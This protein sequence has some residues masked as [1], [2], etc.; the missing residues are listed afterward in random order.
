MVEELHEFTVRE[1]EG[2]LAKLEELGTL[3]DRV[4]D[5][6]KE[7]SLFFAKKLKNPETSKK[8]RIPYNVKGGYADLSYELDLIRH[9]SFGIRKDWITRILERF[10]T[11]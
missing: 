2:I 7:I 4:E 1:L 5:L 9:F 10:Y 6:N 3:Y 8:L 11:R